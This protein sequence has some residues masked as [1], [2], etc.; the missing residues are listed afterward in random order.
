MPYWR[1]SAWYF[2]YFTFIGAYMPYFGVYLQAQG[3]S[4]WDISLLLSLMPTMRLVAPN[5]WSS[6]AERS[7][8]KAPVVRTTA[9]LCAVSF[10]ALFFTHGFTATFLSMALLA[11]FWSA[12][13]PLVEALTLDHLRTCPE[14][15]GS[16][17]LWGSLGFIAAVQGVGA[18]LDVQP[19]DS[20]LWISLAMLM[21]LFGCGL[22]LREAPTDHAA[23]P[24]VGLGAM[25]RRPQLL[26]LL[27]ASFLM[28]AAHGPLYVFYSIHLV[29]HDYAKTLI[30]ALWSLGVVAEILAFMLM[31]RLQRRYP[32]RN[33][34]LATFAVAAL[35]FLM[36]GWGAG[37]ITILV[38]AQLLHGIT[39]G[40]F[41]AAM[42]T[43]LHQWFP[44]RE[45]ARAQAL[46]GSISFGAGGLLGGLLSGQTWDLVGAGWTYS[47]GSLFA[48]AGLLT[49]WRGMRDRGSASSETGD[50][51]KEVT[52]R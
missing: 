34:L 10:T 11:F 45:Q 28:S 5:L 50:L 32:V 36:I 1:L 22:A 51:P 41:H 25:L 33:I 47:M 23:P 31:P 42:V 40:A 17:R 27:G 14:R 46:Y 4:A 26:A 44:G 38:L 15:Y 37:S 8:R 13:L 20:L 18:L 6:L 30:G 16:I 21:G 48:L 7:G 24:A 49:L 43:I 19:I 29:S 3:Y 39:F 12:S 9:L 35:R 2:V 52:P